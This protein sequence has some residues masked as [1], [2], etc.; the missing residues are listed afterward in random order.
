MI[1]FWGSCEFRLAQFRGCFGPGKRCLN[2][3]L[4]TYQGACGQMRDIGVTRRHL[5]VS[6]LMELQ[7]LRSLT[8]SARRALTEPVLIRSWTAVGP[9]K[10]SSLAE[11]NF[12][13]RAQRH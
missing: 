11:Q 2:I 6:R 3:L 12:N 13:D 5:V 1:H 7:G 8:F 10:L 4:K 9:E